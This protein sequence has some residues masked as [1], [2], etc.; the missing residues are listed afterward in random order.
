MRSEPGIHLNPDDMI[1]GDNTLGVRLTEQEMEVYGDI[2]IDEI[3]I[4]VIP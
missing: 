2:V 4:T 3:D 1:D